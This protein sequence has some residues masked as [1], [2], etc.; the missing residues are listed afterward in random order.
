LNALPTLGEGN[1]PLLE[2][3]S[4]G[5]RLDVHLLFK[6]E[7]CNP[8]G[9]YKDRFVAAQMAEF[10]SR[11]IHSCVATSSGNTGASLA[12][13]SARCDVRCTILVNEF[14]PTNKVLQMLAYGAK[15]FRVREFVISSEVTDRVY[16]RLREISGENHVPI[17]VSA[18]RYCPKG[19]QGVEAIADE[20]LAEA[21]AKIDHVFVPVGG[22]GLFCA[23]C[24]GFRRVTPRSPMVHAVQPEGCPTVVSA[25]QEGRNHVTPVTSTTRVSGLAVPFDIDASLALTHLRENGGRGIPVTDEEIYMAQKR[26]LTE[27]GIWCEPAGATAL[28]GC[29]RACENGWVR[30]GSTVACLVTGHGFKDPDSLRTFTRK[31]EAPL[32][33]ETEV[34]D[35][36]FEVEA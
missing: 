5:P 14:A 26:M 19:M 32:I 25:F 28:A 1:T 21:P 20:L 24:R 33:Q 7:L 27:E 34:T 31:T 16:S 12:A 6:L 8:T 10:L 4:I 9:S 13:F 15:V 11:G 29:I 3:A 23:I 35:A 18:Y 36:L 2:S 22:G 17:V 30:P